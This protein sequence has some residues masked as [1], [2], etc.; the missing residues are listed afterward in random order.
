MLQVRNLDVY[1]GNVQALYEI[2][3][4]AGKG[5]ITNMVGAN[6]SGKTTLMKCISGLLKPKRGL[7]IF[8]DEQVENLPPH[9]IVERG[10]VQVPEGRKL[11]PSLTIRENL[12]MGSIHERAK[13]RRAQSLEY[14]YNLFPRLLERRNQ[15]AGTLSGGEQ[16]M[17]AFGRALMSM[18]RVLLLDEPSLGLSPIIVKEI[19]RTVRK[20]NSDGGTILL[21]EQNVRA[22]LALADWNYVIETGRIVTEGKSKELLENE[23]VVKAYFGITKREGR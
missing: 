17:L 19:F 11:F 23:K 12:E 21:V 7:I 2:N 14:V 16:Q 5:K 9:K 20:I 13:K 10:L 6:G 15:L 8:E 22:S 4:E 18:P 3:I 1:Y